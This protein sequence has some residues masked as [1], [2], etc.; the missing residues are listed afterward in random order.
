MTF[1]IL[2]ESSIPYCNKRNMKKLKKRSF[3]I[4]KQNFRKAKKAGIMDSDSHDSR[5]IT[6]KNPILLI[7]PYFS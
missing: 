7:N 4:P 3:W 6:I 2:P 1:D 5:K